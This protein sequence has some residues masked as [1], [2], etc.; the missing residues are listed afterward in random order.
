VRRL[1]IDEQHP[2]LLV[3]DDITHR[4]E[5]AVA[6]VAREHDSLRIHH[7]D[8]AGRAPFVRAGGI[9]TMVDRSEKEHI[10]AFDKCFLIP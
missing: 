7:P 10:A 5:H 3:A 8:E 4:Q 2:D 6:I 9:T 1:E